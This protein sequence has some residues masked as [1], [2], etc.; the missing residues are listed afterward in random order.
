MLKV[1]LNVN[2]DDEGSTIYDSALWISTMVIMITSLFRSWNMGYQR[3]SYMLT[4]TAQLPITYDA[5]LVKSDGKMA[6]LNG[7]YLFNCIVAIFRW[8][9]NLK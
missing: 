7:F 3:E 2:N 6:L 9:N 1:K 4:C 5:I 8:K